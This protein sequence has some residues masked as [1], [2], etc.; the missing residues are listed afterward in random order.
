MGSIPTAAGYPLTPIF[1]FFFNY[2]F[3]E[4][5]IYFVGGYWGMNKR[6]S[7]PFH[8]PLWANPT[9]SPALPPAGPA[10]SSP[11]S[12]EGIWAG[13]ADPDWA[14]CFEWHWLKLPLKAGALMSAFSEEPV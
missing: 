13:W 10:Q 9:P 3:H 5:Y 4:Q 14:D 6:V 11:D 7:R 1:F 8:N 12:H 2:L